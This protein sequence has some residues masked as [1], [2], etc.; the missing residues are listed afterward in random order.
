MTTRIIRTEYERKALLALLGARKLPFTVEIGS[1]ANRTKEQNA[2]AFKWYG[3]IAQQMGDRTTS[4]VRAHCK[5]HHGVRIMRA[6]EETFRT[7]WNEHFLD[8]SY[9]D[10]LKLMVEPFDLPVT[11]L[12][13]V[14][15]LSQYL[16]AIHE[17]F[18]GQGVVLTMPEDR[19]FGKIG[20]AA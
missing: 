11:R 4:E 15:Q 16:D 12:M 13:K 14:A 18:A 9:E 3:E 5:L 1:G 8:W 7:A 2:L 17:E 10:K 6:E 19:R 20:D